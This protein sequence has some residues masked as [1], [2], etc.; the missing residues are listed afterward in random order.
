MQP[1][2]AV[3]AADDPLLGRSCSGPHKQFS[4]Q[5]H[6]MVEQQ[7]VVLCTADSTEQTM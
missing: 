3:A 2:I 7:K 6:T 1:T 4:R 5:Y